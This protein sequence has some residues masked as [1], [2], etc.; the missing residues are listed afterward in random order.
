[1]GGAWVGRRGGLLTPRCSPQDGDTP[2][3]VAAEKGHVEVVQFLVQA[4]ADKNFKTKV[5][6]GRE[7]DVGRTNIVQVS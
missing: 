2:L 3:F 5:M 6:E 4:D 1:M 7:G